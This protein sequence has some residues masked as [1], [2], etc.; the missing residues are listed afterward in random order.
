MAAPEHET[1][2]TAT[3]PYRIQRVEGRRAL[4]RFVELPRAYRDRMTGFVPPLLGDAIK[5]LTP[6]KNPFFEHAESA[7]WL[8]LDGERA[9]GR[10]SATKDDLALD[11]CKDGRGV[12]G[13]FLAPDEAGAALLVEAASAWLRERGL[14]H[15]R[16][17]IELS[18]NY[19]CGLQI[20]GFDLMPMIEINQ[21][22]PGFEALLLAQ[23]LEPVQDLL[24]YRLHRSLV[25]RSRLA[26]GRA[27]AE[28]R[29]GSTIRNLDGRR[30]WQDVELLHDLYV[31]CWATNFGFAPMSH[32]EFREAA[33][34]FKP[35]FEPRLC[36]IAELDGEP[37]GFI[38][39]LPDVNVG[40]QACNGRLFPFGWL[41]MLRAIRRTDRYRVITLGVVPE[42]RGRA[43]DMHLVLDH[44][45][46][47]DHTGLDDAELSW[48]LEDNVGMVKPLINIGA[49][50]A[51][52]HRIFELEL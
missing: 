29:S 35:L 44:I 1:A 36:Q 34:G 30:F 47:N 24:A 14:S 40:I 16:G 45:E 12:F 19:T 51:M 9:C 49:K 21:H 20:S 17:P 48:V 23:G 28:R 37:V 27:L 31:R 18:T 15:M 10:I 8:L 11:W 22:P 46:R 7:Y 26:R 41:K 3:R 32:A 4:K 52:R 33:K 25:D 6:G 5:R 50:E 13:H 2:S 43:I 42:V 39:G 38:F